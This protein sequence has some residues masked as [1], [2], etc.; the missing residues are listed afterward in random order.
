MRGRH[1]AAALACACL[2]ALAPAA[3][4]AR[5]LAPAP[6]QALAAVVDTTHPLD[7]PVGLPGLPDMKDIFHLPPLPDFLGLHKNKDQGPPDQGVVVESAP[8]TSGNGGSVNINGAPR[9][10][11]LLNRA[12]RPASAAVWS[13]ARPVR[14]RPPLCA[15]QGARVSGSCQPGAQRL[16]TLACARA[17]GKDNC[18]GD[19]SCQ[20][21]AQ[22]GSGDGNGNSGPGGGGGFD[23]N[24]GSANINGATRASGSACDAA[25]PLG[26]T[27]RILF[28][29]W[30]L[31]ALVG[32]AVTS[33]RSWPCATVTSPVCSASA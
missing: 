25:C 4:G 26:A 3:A 15:L 16:L 24:G 33:S 19:K 17:A 23:N 18:H 12:L 8:T 32:R 31:S 21:L 5:A 22:G 29:S 9:P 27:T 13:A 14:Q 7:G 1:A 20:G 6:A 2:V 28:G 30:A 11:N 10:I